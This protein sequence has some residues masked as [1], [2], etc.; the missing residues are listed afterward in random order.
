MV[1][2]GRCRGLLLQLI[3]VSEAHVQSVDTPG[4]G[5]GPSKRPLPVQHTTFTRDRHPCPIR[6]RNPSKWAATE[7]RLSPRGRRFLR[8]DNYDA[9]YELQV[10]FGIRLLGYQRKY[11]HWANAS[12]WQVHC[13]SLCTLSW[14]SQYLECTAS[15]VDENEHG[16]LLEIITDSGKPK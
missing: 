16:A 4:G 5:I 9:N 3:N 10:K 12:Q 7:L 11:K 1:K 14:L 6:T 15:I 13:L 8:F 2:H